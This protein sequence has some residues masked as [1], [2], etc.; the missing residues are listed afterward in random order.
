MRE[1]A[2]QQMRRDHPCV[3]PPEQLGLPPSGAPDIPGYR[4]DGFL[5]VGGCTTVYRGVREQVAGAA[6][7][8]LEVAI[9]I[10]R[11]DNPGTDVVDRNGMK[12]E[13]LVLSHFADT[14]LFVPILEA[15]FDETKPE[16]IIVSELMRGG[17]WT[18]VLNELRV[19]TDPNTWKT[20]AST[21]VRGAARM[22]SALH[23][24]HGAGL[25]HGD[26]KPDNFLLDGH[27]ETFLGDCGTVC[28][29]NQS[30]SVLP[31]SDILVP[32]FGGRR[33]GSAGYVAPEVFYRDLVDHRADI[34]SL[35]SCLYSIVSKVRVHA[36]FPDFSSLCRLQSNGK[37]LGAINDPL[38]NFNGGFDIWNTRDS[39]EHGVYEFATAIAVIAMKGLDFDPRQ[40]FQKAQDLLRDLEKLLE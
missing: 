32:E 35:C 25:Y 23:H 20:K 37:S 36:D 11:L 29:L 24:L 3:E 6:D 15:R 30:S 33:F 18:K 28:R 34:F 21:L 10:R 16:Y 40:R 1:T 8:P 31:S 5:G 13:Y 27:G 2:Q 12:V 22:T 38:T 9:K 4:I 39:D 17:T 19:E 26:L 14:G 7:P